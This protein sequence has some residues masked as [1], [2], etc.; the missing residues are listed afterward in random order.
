VDE[1]P[2]TFFADAPAQGH[3][4]EDGSAQDGNGLCT[5]FAAAAS[6]A[7]A[8]SAGVAA[9]HYDYRVAGLVS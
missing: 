5:R 4:A 3:V 7:S 1:P 9:N 2:G 6:A 8:A